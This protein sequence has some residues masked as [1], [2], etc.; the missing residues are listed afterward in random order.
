MKYIQLHPDGTIRA[1]C[2]ADRHDP[3]DCPHI[4]VPD[5][6]VPSD[7]HTHYV[8][9]G[10]LKLRPKKDID[11]VLA[12]R[13]AGTPQEQMAKRL[14]ELEEEVKKLKGGKP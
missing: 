5:D 7:L 2:P 1:V 14:A 12:S 9:N 4:L 8:Q 3:P 6:E 10:K 13:R 11:A